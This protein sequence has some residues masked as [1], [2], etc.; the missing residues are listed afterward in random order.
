MNKKLLSVLLIVVLVFNFILYNNVVFADLDDTAQSP[1]I[2]GNEIVEAS[3]AMDAMEGE[4]SDSSVGSLN[5]SSNGVSLFGVILQ[6][7]SSIINAVPLTL[8]RF[9]TTI[10]MSDWSRL[11]TLVENE[12]NYDTVTEILFNAD[13]FFTV[14][15][16]VFNEISIF[17]VDVFNFD[18]TYTVGLGSSEISIEQIDAILT[19]KSTTAGWF[20]SCR[21]LAM[22]INL[23]VLI[24]VGIRMALSTIASEEAKYKK[25][26]IDWAQSMIVLFVL[27]YI[28]LILIS[29]GESVINIL[30]NIRIALENNG[31]I[32]FE[33]IIIE[34]INL[35]LVNGSGM[36][37]FLYSLFFWFMIGIQCRFC[38]SYFKRVLTIMFLTLIGPFITVTYP[39]DKMGD[40]KAQAFENWFR[41]YMI[42]IAVQPIHAAIYLVFVFTAGNIAEQAPFVAMIFLLCLGRAENIVRNLF[43][44]TDSISMKNVN[45]ELKKK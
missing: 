5:D 39:I 30:Y 9:M 21:L 19:F 2:G 44:I 26:L 24:Y 14:S 43:G 23:C 40:G 8:Q 36:E 31:E 42:N 45:E 38:Y 22:M 34:K 27:H 17:N 33:E 15:K 25:M 35:V 28:M 7:V 37:Y 11:E 10:T 16:A 12:D 4:S 32:G 41:E 3:V 1:T 20:Y 13:N 6:I 18:S 29:L